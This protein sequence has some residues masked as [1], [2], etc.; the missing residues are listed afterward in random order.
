MVDVIGSATVHVGDCRE[1]LRTLPAESVQTCVTSP[2]YFGL[3]DYGVDGQIGLESSPQAYIAV[4]VEVFREVRRVLRPDGTVWLNLG[5]SYAGGGGCAPNA[6][7]NL[8][9]S[10]SGRQGGEQGSRP[11]GIKPPGLIKPKDLM[12]IPARVAIALQEDGWWVRSEIVW[13]KAAPMPESVTD[14]PTCAH[15]KVWL[16]TKAPRYFYDS[17]A[18]AEPALQPVGEER[19]TGQGK[20]DAMRAAGTTSNNNGTSTSFLGSN[21]GRPF[22]NA[23]NVWHLNPEPSGVAT[24]FATM[25]ATLASLCIKAGSRPGDVVLDPFA[26]AGTTLLAADRLQRRSIGIEL[27]PDYARLIRARFEAEAPL[28]LT[29]GAA[30]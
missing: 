21:Q 29:A 17:S 24:H 18:I 2:P 11:K 3:R 25:P 4:L 26:G 20:K 28:F 13:S 27:N 5:D 16:L 9:G 7:S 14:R 22:R 30:A 6:P 8:A 10:K 19:R 12:L 15:E 1:V 23:R